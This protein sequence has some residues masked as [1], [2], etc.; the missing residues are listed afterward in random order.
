MLGRGQRRRRYH[1]HGVCSPRDGSSLVSRTTAIFSPIAS[2][3]RSAPRCKTYQSTLNVHL[4]YSQKTWPLILHGIVTLFIYYLDDF[5]FQHFIG[6]ISVAL[7]EN[8]SVFICS[9]RLQYA[10]LGPLQHIKFCLIPLLHQ[11]DTISFFIYGLKFELAN[12]RII[13]FLWDLTS[14]HQLNSTLATTAIY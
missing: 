8:C 1:F 5:W 2:K 13:Y 12:I 7:E 14:W 11:G 6:I 3:R 9:P 4:L 10:E